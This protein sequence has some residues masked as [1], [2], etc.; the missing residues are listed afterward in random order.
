MIFPF[1]KSLVQFII[2]KEVVG[3]KTRVKICGVMLEEDVALVN[4]SGADYIGLLVD[5]P[6]VRSLSPERAA[7][8]ARLATVPVILLFMDAPPDFISNVVCSIHPAG[9]QL[10]GRETPESVSHLRSM[11]ECEI[12]KGVHLPAS[13]TGH[14]S[15]RES[16]RKIYCYHE[17]GADKIL[18]DTIVEKDGKEI[19]GGTGITYDWDAGREIASG[20]P[21]PV[22]M[23]GGLNPENVCDAIAA[24]R[25]YGVDLASGV[26]KE[27]GIK[28]PAKVALFMERVLSAI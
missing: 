25:P 3:M 10:Q 20:A 23:A 12:W 17:M 8:L 22:F 11:I 9:I 4:R 14:L 19:R 6:S 2:G 16:K 1:R 7:V 26:E 27:K 28:D 5:M 18:L 21:C 13:G 15:I 24:V